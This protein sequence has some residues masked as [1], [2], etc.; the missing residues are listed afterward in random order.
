[1]KQMKKITY[2][3]LALATF[4]ASSCSKQGLEGPVPIGP[5]SPKSYIFFEASVLDVAKTK[6]VELIEGT[7]LPKTE[8]FGVIGYYEDNTQIFNN[9]IA[10]VE[11][12]ASNGVYEYQNP[13]PWMGSTHTFHALYPYNLIT[14]VEVSN[15]TPHIK[16]TQPTSESSMKDILGAYKQVTNSS[17]F[18]PVQLQF[19][20]LLWAFYL[21]ITNSQTTETTATGSISSPALTIRKVTLSLSGFPTSASLKLDSGYTVVPGETG[22]LNYTLYSN[23]TGEAVAASQSKTYGPLLFIPVTG[24]N[25]QVTVEYTTASGIRDRMVYPAEGYKA[26][27]TAFTHGKSYTLNISKTNDKF[28]VGNMFN[29]GNWESANVEHT[30]Q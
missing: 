15:Y 8:D 28:F 16:Y 9:L 10:K 21:N 30:F 25:Y 7:T 26:I 22:T 19:E 1:M 18:A 20:H 3:L 23:E 12:N 17:A 4:I 6:A 24:L 14:K 2:I 29:E 27:S 5:E 13:A 11:W